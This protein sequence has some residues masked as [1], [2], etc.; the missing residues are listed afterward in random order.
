M[1]MTTRNEAT[2]INTKSG[3]DTSFEGADDLRRKRVEALE[4]VRSMLGEL[5]D[6]CRHERFDMIAYLLEMACVEA[7]DMLG[8]EAAPRRRKGRPRVAI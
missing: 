3:P 6:I 1:R 2:D 4:Y 8:R 5:N 7:A